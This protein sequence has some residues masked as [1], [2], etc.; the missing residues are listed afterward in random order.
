MLSL[1]LPTPP[2]TKHLHDDQAASVLGSWLL[3]VAR[4]CGEP[5]IERALAQ[6]WPG[7][8][9]QRL[10]LAEGHI[11]TARNEARQLSSEM[12]YQEARARGEWGV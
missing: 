11:E 1:T 9:A 4:Q 6:D 10:I 3:D 8:K 7:T 5:A 2:K 12:S